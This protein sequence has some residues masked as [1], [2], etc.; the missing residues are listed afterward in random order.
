MTTNEWKAR[1][2]PAGV[3]FLCYFVVPGLVGWFM[4]SHNAV[5][6]RLTVSML[7]QAGLG[8]ALLRKLFGLK[9]LFSAELTA[10]LGKFAQPREKTRELAGQI[11][12]AAG[13]IS[14]VALMGPPAGE[15]LP[16]SRWMTLVKIAALGYAGFLG[17]GIWKLAEP[18]MAYIPAPAPDPD[19]PHAASR[20]RCPHCGQL[21]ED[22]AKTCAFCKQPV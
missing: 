20:R 2:L 14:I 17:Y 4:G 7:V 9:Q 5:F 6:G 12:Q 18:F 19:E 8:I 11:L 15:M 10:W 3:L 22:S 16:D 21:I 13:F 1:L